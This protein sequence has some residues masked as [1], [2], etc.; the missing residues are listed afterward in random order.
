[1]SVSA[2]KVSSSTTAVST[3]TSRGMFTSI[4]T[5][6][7]ACSSFSSSVACS[8]SSTAR[9]A[10][11]TAGEMLTSIAIL[12]HVVPPPPQQHAVHLLLHKCHNPCK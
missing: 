9:G 5:S 8:S 6:T 7:G 4:T 12:T 2:I 11:F 3:L 10:I 1:M